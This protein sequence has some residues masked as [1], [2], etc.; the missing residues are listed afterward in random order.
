MIRT[1]LLYPAGCY[2]EFF[3]RMLNLKETTESLRY[4]ADFKPSNTEEYNGNHHIMNEEDINGHVTKITYTDSDID[5]INRNKWTKVK[6]H[7]EE[8]SIKTFPD[9]PNRELYT[10]SIYKCDLLDKNNHFKRI[11]K[12]SNLEVQFKWFLQ[13]VEQWLINFSDVFKA[14]SIQIN[15]NKIKE[16]YNIF[17][18]SQQKIIEQHDQA[19]DLIAKSN[20]L[21]KMYFDRH[22]NKYSELYFDKLYKELG[23]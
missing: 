7:L 12:S 15:E 6:G 2:G 20:Q 11:E 8:Q 1:N 23:G 13:S 21:G 19:N 17:T 16:Y 18:R 5:L 10:M 3:F 4:S 9:N 22:G 14:L